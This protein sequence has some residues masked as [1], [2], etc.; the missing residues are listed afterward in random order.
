MSSDQGG[1]HGADKKEFVEAIARG[2]AVIEAFDRNHAEMTLSEVAGR[3]GLSPATARRC[4]N[5]L[6]SLGYVRQVG[7]KFVLAARVLS[8]GSAYTRATQIEEFI[9]PELRKLV[10]QFGDASSVSVLDDR[11]ILY[12]AHV[13][14]QSAT[15]PAAAVGVRYPAY[16]TSMG[17][18]M[19]AFAEPTYRDAYLAS[20]PFAAL[21]DR[22][23]TRPEDLARIL[24]EVRRQGY[25][26]VIDELDYGIAALAVPI[27]NGGGRVIAALNT[28]GYSGR[29]T[30]ET[31]V[32][33]RLLRLREA[34]RAIE[35]TLETSPVLV[36]STQLAPPP[37]PRGP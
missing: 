9:V 14:R 15:R 18:V 35:Q 31:L 4:L 16:A 5:T 8:L 11:D 30:P 7:R 6:V 19:L 28:S 21:T 33:G 12:V 1:A 32:E 37:P 3:T 23:A 34:A 2:L 20:G 17:R 13:T 25:S 27:R 22:T 10:E 36:H 29:L 26:V 24:A